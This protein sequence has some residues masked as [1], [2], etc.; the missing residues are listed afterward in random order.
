MILNSEEIRK[1]DK[2]NMLKLLMDFPEQCE[3]ACKLAY[4]FKLPKKLGGISAVVV[5]GLGGS[6]IGGD[7]LKTYLNSEINQCLWIYPQLSF[8]LLKLLF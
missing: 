2:K 3:H 1:I 6:A 4:D 8:T 5:T 7:L